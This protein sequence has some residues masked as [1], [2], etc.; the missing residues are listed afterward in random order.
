MLELSFKIDLQ[1]T[2]TPASTKIIGEDPKILDFFAELNVL[3][4]SIQGMEI[5]VELIPFFLS[6]ND[7]SYPISTSL[8]VATIVKSLLFKLPLTILQKLF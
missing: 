1:P 7:A 4:C 8:P 3:N 5:T 2:D 6:F